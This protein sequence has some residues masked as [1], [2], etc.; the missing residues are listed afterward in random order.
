MRLDFW[1]LSNHYPANKSKSPAPFDLAGNPFEDPR[2]PVQGYEFPAFGANR[3]EQVCEVGAWLFSAQLL[4]RFCDRL[5]PGHNIGVAY[6]PGYLLVVTDGQSRI[7]PSG[8][9][10]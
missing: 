6:N 5:G 8:R 4:I 2:I 1:M 3:V 9:L 7:F 10:S